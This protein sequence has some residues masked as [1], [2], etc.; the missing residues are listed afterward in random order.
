MHGKKRRGIDFFKVV[1]LMA[2]P[3]FYWIDLL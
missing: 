2:D 1:L 3:K